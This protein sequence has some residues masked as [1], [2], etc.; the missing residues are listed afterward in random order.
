M[1]SQRPRRSASRST[2][3]T[4]SGKTIKLNQ[5]A[6]DRRKASK[7]A[8]ARRKAAYLSTLPKEPWKRVLYRLNPKRFFK[9]LFSREGGIMALKVAGIAFV[10]GFLILVGVFAYFRKDLPKIRDIS[11]SNLGGSVTYYDRTGKTILFQ[12]YN[13]RKRIPVDGKDIS[14]YMKEATVAIEDKDFYKH[15]AFDTKG[16]V[17]AVVTDLK[18]GQRQGGSTITQQ[19]VKINEGWTNDRT[20]TRKVKELILAVELEREYEK[21]DILVGYLN[22]ST[23][24]SRQLHKITSVL[25]QKIYH[26]PNQP[27]LRPFQRHPAPY[28]RLAAPNTTQV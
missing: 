19:L 23:M 17:R 4:R 26:L 22:M 21:S 8:S 24:G 6:S 14:K 5:T 12:D 20:I 1:N 25:M 28:R 13:E 9:Y 18:G 3:T 7:E 10:V 16:I 11:G 15:G 2:Y 27:C